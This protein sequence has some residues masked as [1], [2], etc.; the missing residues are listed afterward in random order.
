MNEKDETLTA[1]RL[2]GLLAVMLAMA[3]LMI[4]VS[5]YA[6]FRLPANVSI[7]V[8]WGMDGQPNGFAGKTGGLFLL[9]GVAVF[10]SFLFRLIPLIEPRQRNLLRSFVAWRAVALALASFFL[11]L[12]I[13]VV[14][15]VLGIIHL[16]VRAIIGVLLGVL[17]ITLGNYLGKVRSN[18]MFGIRTPWTLTSNI[19]WD[20]THRLGGKLLVASGIVG[21]PLTLW[22]GKVGF[23]I[24]LSLVIATVVFTVFYSWLVWRSAPDRQRN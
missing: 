16:S 6:W 8:H 13:A 7:P 4:A 21:I 24:F 15:N 22:A 17:F 11:F 18:F 2:N 14:G 20:R 10:T 23:R 9:P 12:H 5:V 3:G 1:R 19:A